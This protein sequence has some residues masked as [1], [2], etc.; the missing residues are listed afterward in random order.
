VVLAN[1]GS[2]VVYMVMHDVFDRLLGMPR[3]WTNQDWLGDADV[4]PRESI[5]AKNAELEASRAKDTSPSLPL[6]E[7]AG[8]YEC[9]LY[10]KLEI[11]KAEGAL[12]LQFGPNIHATLGHW[13]HNS[14]RAKLNF[15]SDDEWLMTFHVVDGE[16]ERVTIKRIFWHESMPEFVRVES[17]DASGG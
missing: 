16:P 8:T 14:F 12:R 5:R 1:R 13:E 10:G 3:P 6:E 11:R 15:P 9:D 7:Y 4:K 17:A 2:G